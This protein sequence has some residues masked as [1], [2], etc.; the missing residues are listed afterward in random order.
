MS[1]DD[2]GISEP[3][4]TTPR[5]IGL[6]LLGYTLG[7]L[8]I[9]IITG[10]GKGAVLFAF[11]SSGLGEFIAGVWEL[12]RGETYTGNLQAM[13]GIWEIGR[14]LLGT[15]GMVLGVAS[16]AALSIY[17]GVLLVPIIILY[18]PVFDRD[19]GWTFHVV[20]LSLI[21][22][23]GIQTFAPLLGLGLLSRVSGVFALSAAVAVWTIA[24]RTLFEYT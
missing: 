9:Y 8:G 18:V 2:G 22:L 15:L 21:P 16:Q 11:I 6:L 4:A 10:T 12:Y 14:F 20:F 5:V 17:Y 7:V 3:G 19:M 1:D 24:A 13:F 23:I